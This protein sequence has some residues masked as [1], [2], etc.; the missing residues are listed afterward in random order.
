MESPKNLTLE[1]IQVGKF[2]ERNDDA[3]YYVVAKGK[4]WF[5]AIKYSYN[6]KVACPIYYHESFLAEDY[7]EKLKEL[8]DWQEDICKIIMDGLVYSD[9]FTLT[10]NN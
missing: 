2:Y 3:L 4:D 9:D 6:H 1:D 10:L 7:N 8:A 5:L